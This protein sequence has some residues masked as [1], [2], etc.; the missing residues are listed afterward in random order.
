MLASGFLRDGMRDAYIGWNNADSIREKILKKEIDPVD[1]ARELLSLINLKISQLNLDDIKI[2]N[3]KAI[4]EPDKKIIHS[5]KSLLETE[6]KFNEKFKK[7]MRSKGEARTYKTLFS[8]KQELEDWEW[9]V[10]QPDNKI[11]I[12]KEIIDL[13]TLKFF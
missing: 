4:N 7:K 6:E 8:K 12:I 10:S 1:L 11:K 5:L 9:L 3:Y 2:L 13:L